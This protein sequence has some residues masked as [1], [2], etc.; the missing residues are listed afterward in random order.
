MAERHKI[1]VKAVPD[2]EFAETYGGSFT[3]RCSCGWE[4]DK[5]SSAERAERSGAAHLAE[6]PAPETN[7]E[8]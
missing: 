6:S 1:T 8:M 7:E 5:R 3:A 2:R 4:S